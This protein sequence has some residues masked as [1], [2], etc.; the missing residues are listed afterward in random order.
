[1]KG[2]GQDER[3]GEMQKTRRNE[4]TIF[5]GKV[6]EKM[7]GNGQGQSEMNR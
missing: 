6:D 7:K 5:W 3:E 2:K 4:G 1:V